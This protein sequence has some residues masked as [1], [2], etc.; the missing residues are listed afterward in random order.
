MGKVRAVF[1]LRMLSVPFVVILAFAP[2]TDLHYI[3]SFLSNVGT[4][5]SIATV[6]YIG[7]TVF[8]NMSGPI[9]SAFSMEML[10]PGERGATIG[11][12]ASIASLAAA[13][14][15]YAGGQWMALHDFQTPLLLMAALYLTSNMCF[16][17][18][19][20]KVEPVPQIM[21]ATATAGR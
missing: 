14:G 21:Q 12:Q 20:R 10:D 5:L 7:R 4:A 15:G 19:F 18:F 13:I 3:A 2:H 11:I 6:A 1:A 17:Y 8:M 9:S 16:W